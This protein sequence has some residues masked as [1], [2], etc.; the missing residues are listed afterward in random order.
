M[1]Q[2]QGTHTSDTGRI[3]LLQQRGDAHQAGKSQCTVP[4]SRAWTAFQVSAGLKGMCGAVWW[5]MVKVD[6]QKW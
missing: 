3:A 1:S 4:A 6:I 2:T 5:T